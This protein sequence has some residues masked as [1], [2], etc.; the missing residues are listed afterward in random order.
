VLAG[1]AIAGAAAYADSAEI[2]RHKHLG[3]AACASSVCH[4]KIAP[5]PGRSVGLNEVGIWTKED[6]H[7]RAYRTLQTPASKRMT[8]LLGLGNPTA[9][10]ICVD[11]HT[12]NVPKDRRGPKFQISDGVGC[13]ACHGG[14][15]KWIENHAAAGR[16]HRQNVADG[17]YASALPA[18]RAELCVSC[19]LG[20]KDKF[21]THLIMAGG[22]PR[23]SFELEAYTT[24][25]PAHFTVD[26]DYKQRKGNIFGMNLWLVGQIET[27]R[28]MLKLQQSDLFHPP[29]IVPEFALY[30]C[31]SCHHPMDRLAK[32]R[33]PPLAV[34]PGT[35]RL[36]TQS[37]V[38]LEA[39]L[40]RLDPTARGELGNLTAAL[41]RAGQRDAAAVKGAA[42]DLLKWLD[43]RRALAEQQFSRADVVEVRKALVRHGASGKV[44]DYAVAEQ[45]VLGVES[46]SYTA[47]DRGSKKAP[48]DRLYA[49]VK[50]GISFNPAQ[51]LAAAKAAAGAF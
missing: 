18:P 40:E 49:A 44:G 25:Q 32:T 22:H 11:C 30:D 23:L 7:S 4:G 5:Q 29:G 39:A 21:A 14:A 38:L 17:M 16:T 33:I 45:I 1:C 46:L 31:H 3:V 28:A 35:L 37:L 2:A 24:N 34:K 27:A 50:D 15:E 43:G 6:A 51:F 41:V 8:A 13:E 10:K 9:E 36:Q 47:G 12:D 20:T 19:H 26:A 42:G 48:L